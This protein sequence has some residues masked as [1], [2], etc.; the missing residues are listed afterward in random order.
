MEALLL[1]NLITPFVMVLVGVLF[2]KRPESDMSKQNGYNTPVSRKSQEHW[3]YAQSIAPAIYISMGKILCLIE[4]I[5]SIALL[6]LKVSIG[7]SVGIGTGIGF[8]YLFLSF[9]VIDSKIEEKIKS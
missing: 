7:A 4:A 1:L 3:D 5:L 2:K 8:V 9:Y 6:V